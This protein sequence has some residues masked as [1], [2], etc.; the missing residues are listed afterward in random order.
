MG[1]KNKKNK[2][3]KEADLDDYPEDLD[4]LDPLKGSGPGVGGGA[5]EEEEAVE[6]PAKPFQGIGKNLGQ[7][8]CIL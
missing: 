6:Q 8:Y 3:Q 7:L 2:K 5:E 1:K 4:D